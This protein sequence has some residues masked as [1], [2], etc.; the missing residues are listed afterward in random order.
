MEIKRREKNIDRK[1]KKEVG[2][3]KSDSEHAQEIVMSTGN[4]TRLFLPALSPM[5]IQ[6]R[7]DRDMPR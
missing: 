4:G 6:M 7:K 3:V 1:I 2:K 5:Y